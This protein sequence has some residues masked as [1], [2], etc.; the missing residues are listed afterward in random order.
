MFNLF[1]RKKRGKT[2]ALNQ[3]EL[4]R[5]KGLSK[6]DKELLIKSLEEVKE[7]QP[8]VEEP[9]PKKEP[10]EKP[11]KEE[12]KEE[13]K[14]ET[15]KE[16]VEEKPKA[17]A[18]EKKSEKETPPPANAWE[19]AI[20][21]LQEENNEKIAKLEKELAEVKKRQPKGFEPQPNPNKAELEDET[22]KR[23]KYISNRW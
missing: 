16:K 2:M 17:E 23:K 11:K 14:V 20:K 3:E 8:K 7:E 13:P 1:K 9:E 15:P 12:P 18:D 21:R 6:E 22:A 19:E 4:E 5:L 10:E